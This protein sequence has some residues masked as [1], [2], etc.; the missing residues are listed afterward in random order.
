MRTQILLFIHEIKR[1][2]RRAWGGGAFE[3]LPP[4]V[5]FVDREKTAAR[6]VLY[7]YLFG[8]LNRTFSES[9]NHM[10]HKD[11]S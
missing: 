5:F 10:S 7:L 3:R 2:L 8:H 4:L 9:Y 11:R 6:S 1:P